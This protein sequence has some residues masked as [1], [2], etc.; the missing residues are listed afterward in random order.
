MSHQRLQQLTQSLNPATIPAMA[1]K[2]VDTFTG[3]RVT[4]TTS[5]SYDEVLARLDKE[6]N[7]GPLTPAQLLDTRGGLTKEKWISNYSSQ[8]G[9]AGFMQF[10][11]FN[12]GS[13]IRL[14]NVGGGL[15]LKRVI[16]GNPLIAITMIQ[17]DVNAGMYVPVELLLRELEGGEG[18]QVVYFL[19]SSLI[20]GVNGDEKLGAAARELDRKFELLCAQITA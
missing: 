19:P 6:I 3:K 2:T 1:S 5:T 20:A 17:H 14:Y 11:E 16:L 12:H 10:G 15:K 8:V 9:P 13:W 7:A 4:L 18:T